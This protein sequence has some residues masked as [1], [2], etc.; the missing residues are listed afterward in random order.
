MWTK[1]VSQSGPWR[2]KRSPLRGSCRDTVGR[3]S[4]PPSW[5]TG[6]TFPFRLAVS[7][8]GPAVLLQV[9]FGPSVPLGPSFCFLLCP[10][11][12]FSGFLAGHHFLP[13]SPCSWLATF[14]YPRPGSFCL[15]KKVVSSLVSSES[16]F[17][18]LPCSHAPAPPGPGQSCSIALMS[19]SVFGS[20]IPLLFPRLSCTFN[21]VPFRI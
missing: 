7:P 19:S 3:A 17:P 21:L 12:L 14:P 10:L 15:E 18:L 11:C 8:T 2:M 16:A 1:E 5:A 4:E 20:W 13:I 6:P 9:A